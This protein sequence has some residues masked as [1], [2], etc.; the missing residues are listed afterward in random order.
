MANEGYGHGGIFSLDV[1]SGETANRLMEEL[2]NRDRFGYMA[3]S[4]GYFD[5]LMSASASS[6]SSEMSD[7]DLRRAGIN[8]GL[9]RFSIG[10]TGSLE[11]RWQQFEEA[12]RALSIVR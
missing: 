11:Q 7:D 3:V 5:T 9:I 12:L 8:P 4:L 2:Q 1:G 6:T 10:Y